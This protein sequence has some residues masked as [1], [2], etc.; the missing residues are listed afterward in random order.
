[1]IL[2][3][4]GI[5]V[6]YIVILG[7]RFFIGDDAGFLGVGTTFLFLVANTLFSFGT[8]RIYGSRNVILFSLLCAF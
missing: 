7:G 1:M 3:G 5:L 2:M 4:T 8:G 6:N